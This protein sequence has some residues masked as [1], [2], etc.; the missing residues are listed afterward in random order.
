M[1]RTQN[2]QRNAGGVKR[3]PELEPGINLVKGGSEVVESLISRTLYSRGGE[4]VW[5]D[6]ANNART[7][8][9]SSEG[10]DREVKVARAFTAHQHLSLVEKA[11]AE[12]GDKTSILA[13]PS[14]NYLYEKPEIADYEKEEMFSQTVAKIAEISKR[15]EIPA[16]VTPSDGNLNWV[17]EAVASQII[18]VQNTSQGYRVKSDSFVPEAYPDGKAFQTTV[19]H[20]VEKEPE[21]VKIGAN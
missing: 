8:F 6:S 16:V 7:G 18:E 1:S 11:E 3:F 13:L 12:T 5:I 10:L 9:I 19:S 14:M 15:L 17:M 20:W 21:V 2:R 4:C